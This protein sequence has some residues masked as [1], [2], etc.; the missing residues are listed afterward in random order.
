[1]ANYDINKTLNLPIAHGE[2]CYF[3]DNDTLKNLQDNHLIALRYLN[4][5]NGSPYDIAGISNK[6]GN[7]LGMMPHP[8][9]A[10]DKDIGITDGQEILRYLIS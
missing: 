3:C 4:N 1:M 10:C 9:R 8:E 6:K 7:V 5:P 2:G